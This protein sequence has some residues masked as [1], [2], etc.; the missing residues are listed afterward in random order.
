MLD[1]SK[2][3][4]LQDGWDGYRGVPP[5]AAAIDAAK[6]TH[7]TPLSGGGVMVE[8][9]AAGASVEITITPDGKIEDV[10]VTPKR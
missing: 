2:L 1:V 4:G 6:Y 8:L 10:C 7:A 9:H 5:T 3:I